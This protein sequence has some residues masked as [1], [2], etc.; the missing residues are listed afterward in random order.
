MKT[1]G[2]L[3]ITLLIAFFFA[4]NETE[5]L[6]KAI[7]TSEVVIAKADTLIKKNRNEKII[8]IG[9]SQQQNRKR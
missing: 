1:G 5:K 7:T 8:F 4:N 6:D 2:A 9:W 3:I